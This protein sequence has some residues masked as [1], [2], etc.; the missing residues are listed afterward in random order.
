LF[1]EYLYRP[2]PIKDNEFT[3]RKQMLLNYTLKLREMGK[4]LET[5]RPHVAQ[6]KG[7]SGWKKRRAFSRKMRVYETKSL[8][9][10]REFE[11]L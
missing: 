7:W 1:I 9:A 6:I 10:E 4:S 11:K 5:V 2:K 8:V 3:K